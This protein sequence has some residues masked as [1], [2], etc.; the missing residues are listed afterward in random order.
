MW[1]AGADLPFR[2]GA[3]QI[4][5]PWIIDYGSNRIASHDHLKITESEWAAFCRDFDDTIAKFNVP[6]AEHQELFAIVQ[7]TKGDIVSS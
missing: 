2:L 7:S 4:D 5:C 3:G 6:E 1:K